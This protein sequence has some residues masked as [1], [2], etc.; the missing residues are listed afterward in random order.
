M[1]FLVTGSIEFTPYMGDSK[2]IEDSRLV[3]ADTMSD[4]SAKYCKWFEA[5]SASYGDVYHVIECVVKE[6]IE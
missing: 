6:T 3:K 1:Y 5:K 4:A 2:T